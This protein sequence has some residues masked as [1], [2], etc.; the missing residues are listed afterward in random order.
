MV[1]PDFISAKHYSAVLHVSFYH[2]YP[3][4]NHIYVCLEFSIK[5]KLNFYL[6]A[7]LLFGVRF[8]RLYSICKL[9]TFPSKR[10]DCFFVIGMRLFFLNRSFTELLYVFSVAYYVALSLPLVYLHHQ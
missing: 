1:S 9:P 10:N 8:S 6:S 4:S 3:L 2:S 5:P 7:C